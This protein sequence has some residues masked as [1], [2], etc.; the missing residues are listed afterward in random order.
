MVM[1]E[2]DIKVGENWFKAMMSR[3]NTTFYVY[4]ADMSV[5]M[6]YELRESQKDALDRGIS[7]REY[8]QVYEYKV[9]GIVK[10]RY[11]NGTGHI[12]GVFVMG[13]ENEIFEFVYDYIKD[14]KK[15]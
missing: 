1:D 7:A 8:K 2:F 4:K 15:G 9:N 6:I 14:V 3:T 5:E 11:R 10:K 13:E 12:H